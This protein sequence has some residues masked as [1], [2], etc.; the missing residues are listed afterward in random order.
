MTQFFYLQLS[1]HIRLLKHLILKHAKL[2][3]IFF[4]I[5]WELG[6]MM[7]EKKLSIVSCY[8]GLVIKE[9]NLIQFSSFFGS[10]FFFFFFGGL[11]L[12]WIHRF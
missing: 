4:V 6:N 3:F 2:F 1:R 10:S 11:I 5:T 8:Y 12:S 7:V 9:Y